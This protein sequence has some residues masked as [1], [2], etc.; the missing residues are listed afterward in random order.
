M[1]EIYIDSNVIVASEIEEEEHHQKSKE[2]MEYVLASEG[3]DT[4]FFTSIFTFLE[5]ASAMIRRTD[6]KNKAYSLLYRIGKSWKESIKP[7]PPILPKQLT[8]FGRLVDRLVETAVEFNTPSADTIHAQTVALYGFPYLVT[9]N[10]KDFSEMEKQISELKVLTPN[11]M[12]EE[13]RKI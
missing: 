7:V 12:L 5:L 2:F 11:E 13:L 8:S 6:D 4:I 9:W 1:I 3:T 10:K